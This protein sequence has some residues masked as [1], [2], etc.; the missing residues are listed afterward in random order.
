MRVTKCPCSLDPLTEKSYRFHSKHKEENNIDH[1]D[2]REFE[3]MLCSQS[4][5]RCMCR[6]CDFRL[7]AHCAAFPKFLCLFYCGVKYSEI[8]GLA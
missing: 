4:A 1:D 3:A 8:S 2:V 5:G 7:H 6:A